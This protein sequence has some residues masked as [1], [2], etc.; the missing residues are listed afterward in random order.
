MDCTPLLDP[1][2][3]P[4]MIATSAA[5]SMLTALAEGMGSFIVELLK[6][7]LTG[8][9]RVPS[10]QVADD[11][12]SA[13]NGQSSGAVAQLR[14]STGWIV[15]ALAV[16]SLLVGAARIA[17]NR[18]GQAAAELGRG[19]LQL[20]VLSGL[21]VPIVLLVTQIGD[22]YSIWII[23]RST[24]GNFESR[25]NAL[26]T[27]GPAAG[28]G[29]PVAALGLVGT[30]VFGFVLAF[31]LLVQLLVMLGHTVG[32][33]LLTGLLPVPAAAGMVGR[34]RETRDKYVAWLLAL[35]LYKPT[36]AT[37]Y[38]AGFWL[39]GDGRSLRDVF[40]G[41]MAIVMAIVALPALMRL[42]SPAA[43][44]LA[45]GAGAGTMAGLAMTTSLAT[46]AVSAGS[47]MR[48]IQGGGGSGAAGDG[49]GGGGG[50]GAT[51]AAMTTAAA[52]A[53]PAGMAVGAAAQVGQKVQETADTPRQAMQT[54]GSIGAASATGAGGDSK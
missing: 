21:G 14:A 5:T 41:M 2:C 43:G 19:M 16:G 53:G 52:G 54:V 22:A 17:M 47:A 49:D 40:A 36:A 50:S 15:A 23:D 37:I 12:S 20:V 30:L 32:L 9:L 3:I 11:L 28:P 46:G 34:G 27:I 48:S 10:P 51:G 24:G 39:I 42:I 7:F 18:S 8:W 26:F 45:D 38:G 25:A 4:S 13:L 35:A 1:T 44:T 31:T 33:T 6:M 29:N